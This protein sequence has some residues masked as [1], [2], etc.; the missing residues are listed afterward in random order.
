MR[1]A[2]AL[3][4]LA[5]A[6]CAAAGAA[7]GRSPPP[8]FWS[9]PRPRRRA[10]RSDQHFQRAGAPTKAVVAVQCHLD[11][12]GSVANLAYKLAVP[13]AGNG[14]YQWL[15][16]PTAAD[17]KRAPAVDACFRT[18]A[19]VGVAARNGAGGKLGQVV[20]KQAD[21]TRTT[22]GSAAKGAKLEKKAAGGRQLSGLSAACLSRGG[23]GR[24][25]GAAF[26][27]PLK[28]ATRRPAGAAAAPLSTAADCASSYTYDLS[29]VTADAD[30]TDQDVRVVVEAGGAFYATD[31]LPK[32]YT[33]P[34]AWASF[35]RAF[36]FK[37][38]EVTRLCVA[39]APAEGGGGIFT[40]AEDDAWA[41]KGLMLGPLGNVLAGGLIL[42]P[43]TGNDWLYVPRPL[44]GQD[45][46]VACCT[47]GGAAPRG[48]RPFAAAN[49]P[50]AGDLV[51][52]LGPCAG[53]IEAGYM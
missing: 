13:P 52:D 8:L 27:A 16:P 5:L 22:C 15:C 37:G 26:A 44:N 19:V 24:L 41:F 49:Y 14:T 7:G 17:L 38:E 43:Y 48:A 33:Q 23:A 32:D 51:V 36:P 4:V 31:V 25:A 46:A 3:A 18:N 39:W 10:A 50:R 30:G 2:T 53:E 11:S 12:D 28:P 42:G 21:G 35:Q 6:A 47:A 29:M 45:A 20:F 34:G 1:P 9:R 40:D